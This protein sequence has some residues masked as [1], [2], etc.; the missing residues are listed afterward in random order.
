[1]LY[2]DPTLSRNKYINRA[3]EIV[4]LQEWR[5]LRK[6]KGYTHIREFEN[7]RLYAAVLWSGEINDAATIPPEHWKPYRLIVVNIVSFDAEGLPL[8]EPKRVHDPDVSCEFRTEREAIESYEDLL[9]RYARCAWLPSAF[10]EGEHHFVEKDNK[11]APPPPDAPTVKAG[12]VEIDP[13]I[14]GSW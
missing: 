6:N 14:V 3:G 10:K 4:P 7:D 2:K 9:V 5:N 12:E 13:A 8:P 1:M 11:L